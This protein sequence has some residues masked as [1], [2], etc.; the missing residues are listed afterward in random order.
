MD[1]EDNNDW[2]WIYI[3]NVHVIVIEER[4]VVKILAKNINHHENEEGAEGY[5][6]E[7]DIPL[8]VV[9]HSE[10]KEERRR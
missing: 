10:D 4:R 9:V 7:K 2:D 5:D 1:S 8:R 3:Q 6:E